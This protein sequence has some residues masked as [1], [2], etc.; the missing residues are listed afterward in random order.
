M[1]DQRSIR[2]FELLEMLLTEGK[3]V[4]LHELAARFGVDERTIRRDVDELHRLLSSARGVEINRGMV[5]VRRR[6]FGNG[7]FS[8]QL[9]VNWPVKSAIARCAVNFLAD[10]SAIAI[11]A[12]TTTYAVAQEI[13]RVVRVENRLRDLIVFTNSLPSLLEL[14]GVGLIIGA[15]G[16]VYNADD[17]AFYS[18][19]RTTA[20]QP[21]LAIV[22]ASGIVVQSHEGSL[23]LSSQRS[24][25]AA[26]MRQLLANV[27]EVMIVADASKIGRRHPWSY[28]PAGLLRNRRVK[29][30]TSQLHAEQRDSINGLIRQFRDAGGSLDLFEVEPVN[31]Q[32]LNK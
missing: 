23:G 18:H 2:K 21:T 9:D 22:G 1:T 10:N 30:I 27:P 3:P 29:L 8:N 17:C 31:S 16:E 6:D 5:V 15:L 12:G 11:T 4:S 32:P 25:E 19:E 24:E 7:Y 20:F 14:T 26:S 13:S 28:T